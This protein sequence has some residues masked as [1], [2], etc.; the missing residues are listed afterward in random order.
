VQN[1]LAK[2]HT[3]LRGTRRFYTIKIWKF[4]DQFLFHGELETTIFFWSLSREE[5]KKHEWCEPRS[6]HEWAWNNLFCGCCLWLFSPSLLLNILLNVSLSSLIRSLFFFGGLIC[7]HSV[8][9]PTLFIIANSFILS[10]FSTAT[11]FNWKIVWRM[12]LRCLAW[13]EWIF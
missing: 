2:R 11:N 5:D 1:K 9:T 8:H 10:H 4:Y 3:E 7:V 13:H 12:V 6:T